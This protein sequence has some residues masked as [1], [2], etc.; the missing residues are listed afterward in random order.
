[1]PSAACEEKAKGIPTT[2]AN[3]N[4]LSFMFFVLVFYF[5]SGHPAGIVRFG[6]GFQSSGQL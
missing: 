5:A 4:W 3:N 6:V 1:V 2:T